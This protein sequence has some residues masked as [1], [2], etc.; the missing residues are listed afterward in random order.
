[1]LDVNETKKNNKIDSSV[2]LSINN[3]LLID[4]FKTLNLVR[5]ILEQRKTNYYIPTS[6]DTISQSIFR[7]I[8]LIDKIHQQNIISRDT[9]IELIADLFESEEIKQRFEKYA[10]GL[11]IEKL[12]K[13]YELIEMMYQSLLETLNK[14]NITQEE[15]MKRYHKIR[16]LESNSIQEILETDEILHKKS[17]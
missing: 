15:F 7:K 10:N 12:K 9:A 11:L 17:R 8:Q 3:S 16:V 2:I 14:G 5:Q 6:F 13:L 4:E 1:M